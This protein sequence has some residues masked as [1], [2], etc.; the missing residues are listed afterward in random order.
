MRAAR[1]FFSGGTIEVIEELVGLA[2]AELIRTVAGRAHFRPR[3]RREIA[4]SR[5]QLA[6]ETCEATLR[7]IRAPLKPYSERP[8]PTPPQPY[9]EPPKRGCYHRRS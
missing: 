2:I 9:L 7:E 8:A 3:A 1:T 4:I 5:R 6:M